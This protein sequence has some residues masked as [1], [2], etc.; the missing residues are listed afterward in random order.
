MN[1]KVDLS[2]VTE[3][4]QGH[5]EQT[6]RHTQRGKTRVEIFSGRSPEELSQMVDERRAELN[7]GGA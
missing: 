6:I 1:R 4:P 5:F 7:Y 3:T 2:R